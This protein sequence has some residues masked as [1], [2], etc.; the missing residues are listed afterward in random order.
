MVFI[1]LS[2]IALV[3]MIVAGCGTR[4][5]DLTEFPAEPGD[6]ALLVKAI[7]DSIHC[8]IK[9]S[10]QAVISQDQELGRRHN[11]PRTAP[12]LDSWGVAGLLKL[13]IIEKSTTNPSVM[14]TPNPVTKLFSLFSDLNLSAQATQVQTLNFFYSVADLAYREAPCAV[15]NGEYA[16]V[17]P[18]PAGS[19]MINSDLKVREWLAGQVLLVGTGA[20]QLSLQ[21]DALTYQ[22]DF[23]IVS[24]VDINPIWHL[25]R[26]SVNSSGTL[27]SGRRDR[28][29]SLILTFGPA[30]LFAKA[31]V[32]VAADQFRAEQIGSS[33]DS[34]LINLLP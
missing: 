5:P 22:V 16:Q 32:G 25:T 11:Q 24:S 21:K 18:H 19:L 20:A 33:I 6:A 14:W 29:N 10:V 4:V 28:T 31:L 12:W 17:G 2:L 34:R 23:Q 30:D 1:R 26:I 13:I 27:L 7:T 8:E 15:V 3:A 9:N